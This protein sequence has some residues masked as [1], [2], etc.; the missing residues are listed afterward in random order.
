MDKCHEMPVILE[1]AATSLAV[2]GCIVGSLI[3]IDISIVFIKSII[4]KIRG[5]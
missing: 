4:A 5:K 3:A 1:Y 2:V